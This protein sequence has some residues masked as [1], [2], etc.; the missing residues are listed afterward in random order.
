MTSCGFLLFVLEKIAKKAISFLFDFYRF[1]QIIKK[2]FL[3]FEEND[4]I[5]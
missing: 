2:L 5:R 3:F 1:F 4:I